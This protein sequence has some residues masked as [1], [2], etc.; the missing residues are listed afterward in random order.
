MP[1]SKECLEN[2]YLKNW[3]NYLGYEGKVS[4]HIEK[5]RTFLTTFIQLGYKITVIV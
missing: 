1:K 3:L 4:R 2:I 5:N